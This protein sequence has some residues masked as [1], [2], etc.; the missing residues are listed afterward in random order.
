MRLTKALVLASQSPRRIQL[1][2]QIGLWPDVIPSSVIEEFD[3]RISPEENAR[4]LAQRKANDVGKTVDDAIVIGADTVVV[5]ENSCLGKPR[6]RTDA[7]R[8]LEML[9]G[10][11]HT[12]FTAFSLLDRPSNRSRTEIEATA[13]TFREL[14]R[15]EVE[16]YVA[17]GAP[18]DKAGAYGIQD[19]YGAV[20]VTRLEGCYY[21]VVGFPLAKFFMT[22]QEFQSEVVQQ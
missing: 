21:N 1:L 22:F 14:P 5:L 15:S 20:F 18:M 10:R 19:D 2:R 9:S 11:T 3:P 12:V 4:L 8:M 6:D 13:V 17:T 7:I 16:E